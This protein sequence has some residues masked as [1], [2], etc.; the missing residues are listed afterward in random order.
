MNKTLI[1]SDV[2]KEQNRKDLWKSLSLTTAVL[3]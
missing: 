2:I 1:R 3:L